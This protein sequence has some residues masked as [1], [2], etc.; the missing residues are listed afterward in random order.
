MQIFRQKNEKKFI[1]P[2]KHKK[3]PPVSR[4]FCVVLRGIEPRFKD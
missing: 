1:T 2:D 3:K 4:R